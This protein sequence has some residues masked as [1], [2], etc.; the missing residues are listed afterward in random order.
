MELERVGAVMRRLSIN[1]EAEPL[2][3]KVVSI[4]VAMI[5]ACLLASLF[6]MR[7]T[8]V[9][10]WKALPWTMWL[11][12]LIYFFSFLFV[13]GTSI[14]Q[15]GFGADL[16]FDTCSAA[17]LF[18]LGAYVSTKFIY[19]FMVD[20]AHIIR[21]T[22]KRRLK[23]K[24]YLFNSFGMLGVFVLVVIMNFIFRITHF[25]NGICIIGMEQPVLLPLISFDA[26][27]NVYLTILFL[28]PL[29]SLHSVK[30]NFWKPWTL[31]WR[32]RRIPRAPPNV[33]LRKLV[34]RTFIGSCCT[35]VSSVTNLSVLMALNGEVA[36]LC[37]LCCN[38][39][40][41]FSA[42][43]INWITSPG[44][45]STL[46][47][48][49][50]PSRGIS[51]LRDDAVTIPLDP[52][53]NSTSTRKSWEQR[54][55]KTPTTIGLETAEALDDADT[56]LGERCVRDDDEADA[57]QTFEREGRHLD[58]EDDIEISATELRGA[59]A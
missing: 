2:A 46:R 4:I 44:Q 55:S 47:T 19:L 53:G 20:R 54:R 31:D 21:Q 48:L 49:T 56:E 25:E 13:F 14:L 30:Y 3:G 5:S 26:A 24:L 11:V 57:D 27:V 36:W 1:H 8:S 39:D 52:D 42:L 41:F 45:E 51:T 18:C 16:N 10:D 32:N 37:L 15:F 22:R 40:I 12:V 29:L 59:Q 9:K 34:I 35:L 38:T 33:R 50:R 7:W 23:S 28:L 58:D 6:V 17:T 43:V